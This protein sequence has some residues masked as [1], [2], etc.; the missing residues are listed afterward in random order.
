MLSLSFKRMFCV[1]TAEAMFS[2]QE[3]ARMLVLDLIVF[4]EVGR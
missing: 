2:H 4:V 1:P 3:V